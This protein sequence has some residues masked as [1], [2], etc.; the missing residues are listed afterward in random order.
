VS[1]KATRTL[2]DCDASVGSGATV[3]SRYAGVRS[4]SA[5]ATTAPPR[6]WPERPDDCFH[7]SDRSLS[8]DRFATKPATPTLRVY[9]S[10]GAFWFVRAPAGEPPIRSRSATSI[11]W[12]CVS[13]AAILHIVGSALPSARSRPGAPVCRGALVAKQSTECL[14]PSCKHLGRGDARRDRELAPALDGTS[15][16]PRRPRLAAMPLKRPPRIC[17]ELADPPAAS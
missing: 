6:R 11:D 9:A 3:A 8:D 7:W 1:G 13:R 10:F 15:G 17:L 14:Q 5:P 2:L 16:R 4:P 12:L